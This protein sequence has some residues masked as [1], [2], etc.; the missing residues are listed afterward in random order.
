[1]K[2]KRIKKKSSFFFVFAGGL[3]KRIFSRESLLLR[4]G[5]K[6]DPDTK[7]GL[8]KIKKRT[9]FFENVQTLPN[10]SECIRMRPS[11]SEWI[12]MGPSTSGNLKKLAK[13]SK[14]L[15]KKTLKNFVENFTKLFSR[16][17]IL[18]GVNIH[19]YQA[20]DDGNYNLSKNLCGGVYVVSVNRI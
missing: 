14:K 5:R 9:I 2:K 8:G 19:V 20:M 15:A 7:S 3:E 16:R 4:G 10:A 6:G 12:R 1:M 13:T 18:K 17:S 11:G